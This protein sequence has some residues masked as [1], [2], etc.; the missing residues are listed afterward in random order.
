MEPVPAFV[1]GG[2]REQEEAATAGPP[3]SRKLRPSLNDEVRAAQGDLLG[4]SVIIADVSA[5][6]GGPQQP[7]GR[8]PRYH[9]SGCS[10]ATHAHLR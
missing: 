1:R 8:S 5:R 6:L 7:Q 2:T 10:P 3:P 4:F 9:F